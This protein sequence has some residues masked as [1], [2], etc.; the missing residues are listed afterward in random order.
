[1]YTLVIIDDLSLVNECG[2]SNLFRSLP[3]YLGHLHKTSQEK[4]K[5]KVSVV[6]VLYSSKYRFPW[7]TTQKA[8]EAP[9]GKWD[10]FKVKSNWRKVFFFL[11]KRRRREELSDVNA[12]ERRPRS[13]AFVVKQGQSFLFILYIQSCSKKNTCVRSLSNSE[14]VTHNTGFESSS[15]SNKRF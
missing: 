14:K 9:R 1:M 8:L 6:C 12:Q 13:T 11:K 2:L 15:K 7:M 4:V 10:H 5:K 3:E